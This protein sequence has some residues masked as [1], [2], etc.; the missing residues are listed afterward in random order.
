MVR[1]LHT[2]EDILLIARWIEGAQRYYLQK[3]VDSGNILKRGLSSYSKETM[4]NL[5][6]LVLPLLP[7]VEL[8]G[9]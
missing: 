6:N 3:F 4:K 9:V 2:S 1:E 5:K 8:R 7:S